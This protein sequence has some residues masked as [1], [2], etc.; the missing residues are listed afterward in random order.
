MKVNI[1][2]ALFSARKIF[3]LVTR[4]GSVEK[5]E[6]G[7][8]RLIPG[9]GYLGGRDDPSDCYILAVSAAE[10]KVCQ[11]GLDEANILECKA[12]VKAKLAQAAVFLAPVLVDFDPEVNLN[13]HADKGR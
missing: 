11:K 8:G 10:T 13:R 12:L 1:I 7:R 2:N 5:T 6:A 9:N 3:L 4:A